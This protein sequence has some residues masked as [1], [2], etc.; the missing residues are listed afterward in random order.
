MSLQRFQAEWEEIEQEFQQLQRLGKE[1]KV[2][3]KLA[4]TASERMVVTVLQ[5]LPEPV[6]ADHG[7]LLY[8]SVLQFNGSDLARFLFDLL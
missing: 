6:H 5:T 4:R 7:K 1:I 8:S 2:Q 3:V